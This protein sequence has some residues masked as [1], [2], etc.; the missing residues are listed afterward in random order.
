MM[1]FIKEMAQALVLA[2]LFGGPMFFYF[3]FMMKP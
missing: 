2:A 1:D 3:L